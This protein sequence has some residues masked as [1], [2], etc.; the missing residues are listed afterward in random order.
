MQTGDSTDLAIWKE[1]APA[2]LATTADPQDSGANCIHALVVE[3]LSGRALSYEVI[4]KVEGG[5]HVERGTMRLGNPV[6]FGRD[7]ETSSVVLGGTNRV[8]VR[9]SSHPRTYGPGQPV[10]HVPSPHVLNSVRLMIKSE[11]YTCF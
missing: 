4:H 11:S 2:D 3:N 10:T 8:M 6:V 9:N 7:T 1:A 5:F